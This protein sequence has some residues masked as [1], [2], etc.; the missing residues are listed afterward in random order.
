MTQDDNVGM[1]CPTPDREDPDAGLLESLG[2]KQE[3]RREFTRWSTLS[4]AI[5]ILGVLGSGESS[6]TS[7]QRALTVQLLKDLP[8]YL[9]VGVSPVRWRTSY[10]CLGMVFWIDLLIM[11]CS[12]RWVV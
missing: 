3:F 4:Y 6:K 11:H 12:I 1:A 10:G 9:Q 7:K 5:S 8:Q 2:Y